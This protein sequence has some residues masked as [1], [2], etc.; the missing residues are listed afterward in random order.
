MYN[1]LLEKNFGYFGCNQPLE[2]QSNIEI[3]E[4]KTHF[5]SGLIFFD[6]GLNE[7]KNA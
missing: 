6:D 1:F 5:F 2:I 3:Y 4:K 7:K